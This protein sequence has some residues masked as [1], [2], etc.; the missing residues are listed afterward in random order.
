ML[1][2]TPL[3]GTTGEH[4]CCN[5]MP[6]Y[7]FDLLGDL[8]AHDIAGHDCFDDKEAKHDGDLLAHRFA[9]EKPSLAHGSNFVSVKNE[10]GVEI[11]Q[12]PLRPAD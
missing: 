12:A 5:S 11:H 10:Q 3:L 4:P 6:L 8:P 7:R 1:R 9:T 2:I